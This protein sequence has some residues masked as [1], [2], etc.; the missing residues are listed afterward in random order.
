M[1]FAFVITLFVFM[2]LMLFAQDHLSQDSLRPV[3]DKIRE[4]KP[5]ALDAPIVYT[6]PSML[7]VRVA[8]R[9][10]GEELEVDIYYPPD[11]NFNRLLPIVLIVNSRSDK[12][13]ES[14]SLKKYF[15]GNAFRNTLWMISWAQAIAAS[16]MI[17]VVYETGSR[18]DLNV[19]D[20]ISHLSQNR[21]Y[22]GVDV[23]NIGILAFSSDGVL[24]QDLVVNG[25]YDFKDSIR[26]L[27]LYYA[28]DSEMVPMPQKGFPIL[29]VR[30]GKDYISGNQSDY[31][32]FIVA[33]NEAGIDF[34]LIDYAE[35]EHGFDRVNNTERSREIITETLE[36]LRGYLTKY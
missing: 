32:K 33:A 31:A 3:A 18:P 8:T 19:G 29:L 22:L 1:K 27:V 20:L 21:Q 23:N 14:G 26:C 30:P 34:K 17:A 9:L 15:G 6:T 36:Y 35:G 25:K 28:G 16:G 11:H 13:Y 4:S 2:P 10:Y 7:Q 24:A 5:G 12:V